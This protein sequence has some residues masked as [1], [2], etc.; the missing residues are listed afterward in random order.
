MHCC[1]R[2]EKRFLCLDSHCLRLYSIRLVNIYTVQ[3]GVLQAGQAHEFIGRA[4]SHIGQLVA[5]F[6][7]ASYQVPVVASRDP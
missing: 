5:R 1:Q 2:N 7:E 4:L 6:D 3:A